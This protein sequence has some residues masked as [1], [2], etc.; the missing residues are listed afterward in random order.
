MSF[1]LL[2]AGK[3]EFAWRF[4]TLV[5]ELKRCEEVEKTLAKLTTEELMRGV[6]R[7]RLDKVQSKQSIPRQPSFGVPATAV[8]TYVP[9]LNNAFVDV[10]PEAEQI[11]ALR[12]DD[13]RVP[14]AV[15]SSDVGGSSRPLPRNKSAPRLLGEKS[16][17]H[18]ITLAVL[19]YID[20]PDA[21]VPD[22][23]A[24]ADA[25]AEDVPRV[26]SHADV[27]AT[28]AAPLASPRRTPTADGKLQVF[29][30]AASASQSAITV[31]LDATPTNSIK[32]YAGSH[33]LSKS[34]QSRIEVSSP[35]GSSKTTIAG[36][37]IIKERKR[38]VVRFVS[39]LSGSPISIV[40]AAAGVGFLAFSVFYV[41]LFGLSR[42]APEVRMNTNLRVCSF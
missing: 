32:K 11:N 19:N 3:S 37:N 23:S 16:F 4:P 28:V 10:H 39:F 35:G 31:Q 7:V 18:A 17:R 1:S 6:K 12:S 21:A 42:P 40:A 34:A 38:R 36:I 5:E 27:A 25:P 13:T 20:E 24:A 8:E 2:Q 33:H 26:D 30:S 14:V 9:F 15:V 22:T 41:I 29:G